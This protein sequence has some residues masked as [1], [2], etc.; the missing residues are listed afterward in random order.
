MFP[1]SVVGGEEGEQAHLAFEQARVVGGAGEAEDAVAVG[2]GPVRPAV[3]EG[4]DR[5]FAEVGEGAVDGFGG[6]AGFHWDSEF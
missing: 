4:T 5:G 2:E 3:L 1:G 6:F